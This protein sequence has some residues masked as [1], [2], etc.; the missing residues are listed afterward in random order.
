MR[1]RFA[2]CPRGSLIYD[3]FVDRGTTLIAARDQCMVGV[4]TDIDKD[5]ASYVNAQ[6]AATKQRP[7][8]FDRAPTGSN[9]QRVA[10]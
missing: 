8:L 6:L 1:I 2:A 7:G 5:Y 10:E 9:G 3:P 4:E